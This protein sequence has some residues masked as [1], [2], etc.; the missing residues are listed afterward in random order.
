MKKDF[1]DNMVSYSSLSLN[2]PQMRYNTPLTPPSKKIAKVS[3]ERLVTIVELFR[4]SPFIILT[5]DTKATEIEM[6]MGNG[7]GWEREMEGREGRGMRW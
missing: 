5:F 1:A 3:Y 6:G 4:T 2:D 7:L